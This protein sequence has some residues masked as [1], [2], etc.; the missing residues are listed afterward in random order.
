M[1]FF[2]R[3]GSF[4]NQNQKQDIQRAFPF[5][6]VLDNPPKSSQQQ[7]Q[8]TSDVATAQQ[9]AQ[10]ILNYNQQHWNFGNLIDS[11]NQLVGIKP[12]I[13]QPTYQQLLQIGG[14]Q[15]ANYIPQTY[16][17]PQANQFASQQYGFNQQTFNPQRPQNFAQQ[18]YQGQPVRNGQVNYGFGSPYQTANYQQFYK[19]K[20]DFI[21]TIKQQLQG[22]QVAGVVNTFIS[23]P[24]HQLFPLLPPNYTNITLQVT[25]LG[26]A[27][28]IGAEHLV[29]FFLANGAN[30][31]ADNIK[32]KDSA[33]N[34]M[35]TQIV[36]NTLMRTNAYNEN[37]QLQGQRGQYL[38][39]QKF[40]NQFSQVHVPQQQHQLT[41]P[42][43]YFINTQ[44]IE[45]ILTC[46]GSVGQGVDLSAI[47]PNDTPVYTRMLGAQSKAGKN[48]LVQ[49]QQSNIL[50]QL[51]KEDSMYNM[52]MVGGNQQQF[53]PTFNLLNFILTFNGYKG[54]HLYEDINAQTIP[55]G[56]TP[57]F[58]LLGN[59]TLSN[60]LQKLHLIKL[61]VDSGANIILPEYSEEIKQ[62]APFVTD[63]CQ[64]IHMY[65]QGGYYNALNEVLSTNKQ[66]NKQ[67]NAYATQYGS[68][69]TQQLR[70]QLRDAQLTINYQSHII[71]KLQSQVPG[72]QQYPQPLPPTQNTGPFHG[73]SN[74][75]QGLTQQPPAYN[76]NNARSQA[77]T[78]A[79]GF[80][81]INPN[82][83]NENN[84]KNNY[85]SY[86]SRTSPFGLE[87][88]GGK[89]IAL[90]TFHFPKQK[91]Y[92][93]RAFKAVRPKIAAENA[94]DFI[95]THY[96]VGKKE[97]VF[98]IED[99]KKGTTYKYS[100]KTDKNGVN[101]LKS[102]N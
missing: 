13:S 24:L 19:S 6:F 70:R 86:Q 68:M 72:Q 2:N 97:I 71:Q 38:Y 27:A 25:L 61:L 57:L 15:Q 87:Q 9:I 1:N 101:I 81:P 91:S 51:T 4:F 92:N 63:V 84:N 20:M 29:I 65:Y 67:C 95:K 23:V 18:Y 50:I 28:L 21:S 12:I 48:V 58:N 44:R 76:N 14:N 26:L 39:G 53:N 64:M 77:P 82:I 75:I 73:N 74:G 34:M 100:A 42:L 7:Q 59:R 33:Y 52:H 37:T 93:E 3:V 85:E 11:N 60:F 96:K 31:S 69:S 89:K 56:L 45:F 10:S 90:R 94:Y 30:P 66:Y 47:V 54:L 36:L 17:H 40:Q 16:Y 102:V 99:R 43:Q 98:T 62:N 55:L 88:L 8:L 32:N 5:S 22:K 79:Q 46:L 80:K 41:V 35:H 78:P 49:M 83:N